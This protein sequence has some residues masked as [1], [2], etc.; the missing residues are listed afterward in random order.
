[1]TE[2]MEGKGASVSTAVLSTVAPDPVCTLVHYRNAVII[3]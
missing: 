2:M 3:G 1:M